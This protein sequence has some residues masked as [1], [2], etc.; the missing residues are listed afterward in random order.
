MFANNA[1]NEDQL[2]QIEENSTKQTSMS[3]FNPNKFFDKTPNNCFGLD[4][5]SIINNI[6]NSNIFAKDIK[7]FNQ[8][9]PKIN[10]S[11]NNQETKNV[12]NNN[13]INLANNLNNNVNETKIK[14]NTNPIFSTSKN[15]FSTSKIDN[16][17]NLN[18]S[19]QLN[20]SFNMAAFPSFLCKEDIKNNFSFI[21]EKKVE[22]NNINSDIMN[23]NNI[24]INTNLTQSMNYPFDVNNIFINP[25]ANNI[26]KID[27]IIK[28]KEYLVFKNQ[29]NNFINEFNSTINKL[30][31]PGISQLSFISPMN[32]NFLSYPINPINSIIKPPSMNIHQNN[33]IISANVNTSNNMSEKSK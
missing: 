3:L 32:N 19:E 6:S 2:K 11:L 18:N 14:I 28:Y 1:L 8:A 10:L 22:N 20:N 30:L 21:N 24:N 16:K 17:N 26:N 27:N 12:I 4:T 9:Q 25:M 31:F 29:N 23:N 13:S 7:L 33:N 15:L 5:N